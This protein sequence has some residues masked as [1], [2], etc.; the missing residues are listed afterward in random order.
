[1]FIYMP[2]FAF[3]LWI[4]H[5]KKRWYYFDHG[6]FTIHY[7][8]FLLLISL[9]LILI[10]K[11]FDAIGDSE[12]IDVVTNIINAVG[13]GWMFYYFFP[14]HHRFYSESHRKSLFKSLILLFINIFL[15]I[16]ILTLFA[17]YTFLT[18]E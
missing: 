16:I 8:S 12:I 13:V 2:L 4:F 17:L 3:F 9:L 14:A 15:I 5:D 1:L 7:F 18:I 6:I 10:N 11:F